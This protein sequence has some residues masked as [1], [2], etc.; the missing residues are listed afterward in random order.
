MRE[1]AAA[2][3]SEEGGGRACG[4]DARGKLL[5]GAKGGCGV[6]GGVCAVRQHRREGRVDDARKV[7]LGP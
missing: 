7:S 3:V 5:E 2:C 6:G 4:A 1:G